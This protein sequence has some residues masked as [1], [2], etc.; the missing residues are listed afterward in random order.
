MLQSAFYIIKMLTQEELSSIFEYIT[1]KDEY[2]RKI[3]R[4]GISIG[5]KLDTTAKYTSIYGKRYT[6]NTLIGIINPSNISSMTKILTPITYEEL[7]KVLEYNSTTGVFIWKENRK[8]VHKGDTAGHIKNSGY[9]E[10]RVGGTTYLA[11]RLAWLYFHKKWPE[12]VL[13]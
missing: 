11:H 2:Y 8:A 4:R 9:V 1:E 7:I 13:L 3:P 5:D 6:T 12:S 10:I